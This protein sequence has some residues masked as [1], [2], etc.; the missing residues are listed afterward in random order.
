MMSVNS[1]QYLPSKAEGEHELITAFERWLR[2][3]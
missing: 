2:G 1:Q 3:A